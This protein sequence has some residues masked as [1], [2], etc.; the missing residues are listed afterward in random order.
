M[1]FK[2]SMAR[3]VELNSYHHHGFGP[4][5]KM[6]SYP[7]E[8]LV[9]LAPVMFVAGLDAPLVPPSSPAPSTTSKSQDA[10]AVLTM[11]L[12]DALLNQRKVAI[13]QPEKAKSFQVILVDRDVRFPPRKMAPND[14]SPH[15]PGHSPL[16]P[17]TPSSPLHPDGLIAP[18]WIRKHT[19]LVP[20]VFVLFMRIFE[21]PHT[22]PRSPLDG[23]DPDRE[24]DREQ[25]ERKRDVDLAAYIALRKKSTNERGIKLTV[26]LLASRRMLDDPS[27]DAR[28]TFIR[29]QSGLDARAALFVLSP[30]SQAELGDFVQRCVCSFVD[31][32][33]LGNNYM[34]VYNRLSTSLQWNITRP[35]LNALGASGIDIRRRSLRIPIRLV[36]LG[37]LAL[38]GLFDPRDG[39]C[40]TSTKWHASPSFGVKMKWR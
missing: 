7:P 17:L 11:R 23:A 16:S 29:K 21:Y 15:V 4:Q 22:A 36:L 10:F 32:N 39:P 28:L 37:Q 25:E 26:V 5:C 18:I 12:R 20:S 31:A 19:T 35:I 3:Q 8:L 1:I 13:W 27:L 24:R 34:T 38:H 30:V 2:T 40:A 9:Q 33:S 14:D 6:N